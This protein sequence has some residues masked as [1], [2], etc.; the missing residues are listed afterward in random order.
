MH[1]AKS[2]QSWIAQLPSSEGRPVRPS[3]LG[4]Y[5]VLYTAPNCA[6]GLSSTAGSAVELCG[7]KLAVIGE[8]ADKTPARFTGTCMRV[9]AKVY[10]CVCVCECPG[11]FVNLC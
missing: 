2:D 4:Q 5:Y 3:R 10:V 7:L 11:P 1:E 8:E 9:R 6:A